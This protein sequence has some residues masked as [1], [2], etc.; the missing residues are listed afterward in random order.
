[1]L[2]DS[3]RGSVKSSICALIG[4]SSCPASINLI[5]LL[6]SPHVSNTRPTSGL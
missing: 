2:D 5:N 4:S 1:M 3:I 6:A